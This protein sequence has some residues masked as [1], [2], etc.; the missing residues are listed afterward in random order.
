MAITSTA[1]AKSIA[2]GEGFACEIKGGAAYC[3]GA[4]NYGVLG[5][6]DRGSSNK[7]QK[8]VG[9][10]APV[11]DID[12]GS[13]HVC[14]VA[15][16]G[17][18]CWG[19]NGSWQALGVPGML[20]SEVPVAVPGLTAGVTSIS[21][22]F[23]HSCA[24]MNSV[25]YCF[26]RSSDGQLGF[27]SK[28]GD[29]VS[30]TPDTVYVNG[31]P[32]YGPIAP[33]GLPPGSTE[34]FAG[35]NLSCSIVA[36]SAHC[37][38]GGV[39]VQPELPVPG[40]P[41]GVT[42][43][44]LT[45]YGQSCIV[46]SGAL[47]CDNLNADGRT[48]TGAGQ[49]YDFSKFSALQQDV[50]QVSVGNFTVCA[51]QGA[52]VKCFGS[53]SSGVIG[54]SIKAN[55]IAEPTGVKGLESGVSEIVT[56]GNLI[57]GRVG[58]KAKCLGGWPKI[59]EVP[60]TGRL[61]GVTRVKLGYGVVLSVRLKVFVG[62]KAVGGSSTVTLPEVTDK[63]GKS[64]WGGRTVHVKLSKRQAQATRRSLAA[65]PGA[66]VK[67]RVTLTSAFGPGPSKMIRLR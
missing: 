54:P 60:S 42:S 17:A 58:V 27:P 59:F 6:G 41:A 46:A 21:A 35:S 45:N 48:E 13:Y 38:G 11:T 47:Y 24:V 3:V 20:Q 14:A 1:E 52:S 44:A 19:V 66:K 36:A 32:L 31:I 23:R 26:G 63:F 5:N 65:R 64:V 7:P 56:S 55:T 25:P 61:G 15:A 22:G 40:V 62:K 2:A 67:L 43:I 29:Y 39:G 51:L 28:P 33:D 49:R 30:I 18:Y 37:W 50:S 10:P 4:D 8:V 57:C 16:G 12:A 34:A 9:L 53:N